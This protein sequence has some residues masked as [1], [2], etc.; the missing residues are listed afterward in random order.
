MSDHPWPPRTQA[1]DA[2]RQ[3]PGPSQRPA[4]EAQHI[5]IADL[6]TALADACA[7]TKKGLGPAQSHSHVTP[8]LPPPTTVLLGA[9]ALRQPALEGLALAAVT[10]ATAAADRALLLPPFPPCCL[11]AWLGAPTGCRH[12][13][14]FP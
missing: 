2:Y 10:D 1:L 5:I 3:A 9:D 6:T 11:C 13:F 7:G 8:F 14:A 12:L 4:A